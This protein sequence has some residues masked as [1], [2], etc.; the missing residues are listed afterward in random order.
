MWPHLA[1]FNISSWIIGIGCVLVTLALLLFLTER[2]LSDLWAA[3]LVALATGIYESLYVWF[4]VL[5]CIR[6][7]SLLLTTTS[8]SEK[9]ARPRF[10]WLRT[11]IVA[12][13]AM[14]G[15]LAM[16]R[17]LLAAFSLKLTYVQ[18]FVRIEDFI[19]APAAALARTFERCWS[20]ISGA[21]P[22]FLG[23]GYILALL[24]LLGLLVL[25]V[26][27]L[28]REPLRP[29]QRLLGAAI[30]VAALLLAW[31]PLV[32]SAGTV[33]ARAVIAWIPISA[34]LAGVALSFS[35]RF[36]KPF[37]GAL[38]VALFFSVWVTVSLFYTDHLAR[39]RDQFLAARIMTRI[40]NL[41][42]NPPPGKIPFVVVGAVPWKSDAS[43]RKLEI[44]GDSYFD[45][46]H[47]GGNPWRIAAYLRTLGVDT[48]E[49]HL[50]TELD[51]FRPAI[52]AMPV[53]PAAGSVAM[54][55]GIVVIK[56]APV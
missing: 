17:L 38:A 56:L 52:A 40:D 11:G 33:P 15:Y 51:P 43:F 31:S 34:F 28:W 46:T 37:Y 16:R 42:P 5:I 13:G 20:L 3:C 30:F 4:L 9:E 12:V 44:F 54:V 29:L 10:P 41:L 1:E 14:L 53:W 7:L 21:D 19:T 55:N 36:E 27:L 18:G 48:L 6:H 25:L 39:Q 22:I 26:R 8:V 32:V 24:P 23:Y 45:R 50:L 2:R 49:P 35:G 47:E